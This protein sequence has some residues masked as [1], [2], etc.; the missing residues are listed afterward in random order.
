MN[1]LWT[2][3]AAALGLLLLALGG[4][5]WPLLRESTSPAAASDD[6]N[7]ERLR[8][9]YRTQRDELEREHQR[10][11]LGA[12]DRAQAID[13][14]ER[15]LIED[16]DAA[17]SV[18][19][20]RPDGPWQRRIPA[21]L[22]SV[23]LPLGALALYLHVGDPG[24]A[25][26]LASGQTGTHADEG[27]DVEAMVARLDERLRQRPDDLEGWVVLARSREVMEQFDAAVVAY[28]HA[29]DLA[30][31][32]QAPGAI[33]GRLHADLADAMASA[34]GGVLDE[35]V[36]AM[37]QAALTLD[38]DQPKALALA[39]TVALQHGDLAQARRHWQRLVGLLEPGSDMA[40]RVQNDLDRLSGG[41]L[42]STA[43]PVTS[44]ASAASVPAVRVAGLAGTIRLDPALKSRVQ[45]GDTVF[46]VVRAPATGRV[47]VAVLRMGAAQLPTSFTLDDSHAM[48]P[49]LP[50]SRFDELSIEARISRTGT[51]Q[52]Q[53]GQPIS[54]PQSVR[55]GSSGLTLVI[56]AVEP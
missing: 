28:R 46:I 3:W 13:E 30:R 22:L 44:A 36:Q 52:R 56:D 29:V 25:A 19:A 16:L 54:R 1:P 41:V 34:Q 42:S 7:R 45:S 27:A 4:L 35:P 43:S 5:L 8:R 40:L 20:A 26:A 38:P 39:G 12:E 21:A 37:L 51:A 15:R 31:R 33:Q 49:E 53:T 17:A 32:Q 14:L 55:K 24:S 10:Q 11:A 50:L 9:L 2:L 6:S 18:P 23:L 47:P 48:S